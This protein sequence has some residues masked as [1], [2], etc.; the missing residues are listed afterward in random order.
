[1]VLEINKN[2]FIYLLK[3]LRNNQNKVFVIRAEVKIKMKLNE[4]CT[5][6]RDARVGKFDIRISVT[7]KLRYPDNIRITVIPNPNASSY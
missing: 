2:W 1:M 6:I 5:Q 3:K 4:K 7:E